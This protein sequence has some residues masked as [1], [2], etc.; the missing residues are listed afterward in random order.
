GQ[1]LKLGNAGEGRL[2]YEV[3]KGNLPLAVAVEIAKVES[4]EQQREFLEAYQKENLNQAA[5][6]TIRRIVVQRDVF[7]KT[8]RTSPRASKC[9]SAEGLVNTLKKEAQR[10]KLLIKK[11]KICDA[12]VIFTVEAMRRLFAD[13]DFVTLLRAEKVETMPE[14]LS[15]MIK[16]G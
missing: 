11:T 12:R 6:R 13:E 16:P 1:L 7:G 14:E 8:L 15:E 9:A 10:Q 3:I 2:I 4:A 5:I